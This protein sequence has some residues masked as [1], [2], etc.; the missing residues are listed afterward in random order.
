MFATDVFYTEVINSKREGNGPRFVSPKAG[1]VACR[2]VGEGGKDLD[3]FFVGKNASLGQT[4]HAAS[5]LTKHVSVTGDCMEVILVH[6]FLGQLPNW[7]S[8]IF[9]SLHGSA[10]IDFFR[11]KHAYWA[12]RVEMTLFI[13]ILLV[14][15]SAVGVLALPGYPIKFPPTVHWTMLGSNFYGKYSTTMFK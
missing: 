3:E 4:V 10:E 8:H 9:V 2:S 13:K 11:S 7:D 6:D 14:V 1:C 12:P 15:M 5:N